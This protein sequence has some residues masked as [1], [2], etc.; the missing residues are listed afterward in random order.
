MPGRRFRL[1]VFGGSFNP[2]HVGHLALAAAVAEETRLDRVLWI[3]AAVSPHKQGRSDLVSGPH[4]LALVERATQGDPL[5]RA[6]DIELRRAGVSYTVDTLRALKE[7]HSDVD[8]R[9]I[10]G[11][12]SLAGLPTWRE[13]E[14]IVEL[15]PPLV[16]PRPGA[17]L[18]SVPA[19]FRD[20]ATLVD[21][22]EVGVSSTQ[23]RA[24]L[25][26][27]RSVRYLVPDAVLAYI[28]AHGLYGAKGETEAAARG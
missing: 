1:G 14:A 5:F 10:L 4:R 6:S 8:L 26:A 12:D 25:A 24:R 19:R 15:A 22:P 2:P 28:E 16:Y 21:A 13:P 23:I 20:A 27:G 11:G 18:D 7:A 9:L 3:P 17:S